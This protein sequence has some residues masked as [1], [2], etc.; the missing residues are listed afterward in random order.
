MTIITMN[1]YVGRKKYCAVIFFSKWTFWHKIY[2]KLIHDFHSEKLSAEK[3]RRTLAFL[4]HWNIFNVTPL[5]FSVNSSAW[6]LFTY[7]QAHSEILEFVIHWGTFTREPFQCSTQ[8]YQQHIKHAIGTL[9][10]VRKLLQL[11]MCSYKAMVQQCSRNRTWSK[12]CT[13]SYVLHGII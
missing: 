3:C 8:L 4:Y 11:S 7:F 6:C 9:N 13:F 2:T 5:Q 12:S 1:Q 10:L